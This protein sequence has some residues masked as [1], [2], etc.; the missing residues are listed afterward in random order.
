MTKMTYDT[1]VIGAGQAG[2][3]AGYH[4]QQ[5]GF[6]FLILEA[7]NKLGGSWPC[8]HDSLILNSPAR[9]SSLPGLPFPGDPEHYPR[10]DE[11]VAYLR[12]YAAHFKLPV[13]TGVRVSKIERTGLTFRLT[14]SR[15]RYQTRTVVAA[16]GFFGRPNL[17]Y[18]P[19]QADFRGQ[20]LHAADYRRP[21]PFSGQRIV[22]V[23]GG[24]CRRA[25]WGGTGSGGPGDVGY[26]PSDSLSTAANVWTGYS[27]LVKPDRS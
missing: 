6:R 3:A 22:V 26:P 21:E 25:D 2:L 11:A 9:Y 10:R 24:Q 20:R 5:A 27:F 19:G 16:T 15:G 14:T 4:L 17:P 7:S 8:F 1:I 13:V 18:I 12:S 23:G